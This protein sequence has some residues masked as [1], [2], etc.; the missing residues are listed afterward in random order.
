MRLAPVSEFLKSS[1]SKFLAKQLSMGSREPEE[2]C[3]LRSLHVM[4]GLT[5]GSNTL[6][7]DQLIAGLSSEVEPFEGGGDIMLR[8]LI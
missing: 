2:L 5:P 3:G 6:A 4:F 7:D 8:R 1:Q